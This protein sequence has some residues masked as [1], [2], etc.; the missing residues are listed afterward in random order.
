M[1]V[2]GGCAGGASTGLDAGSPDSGS[3]FDAGLPGEAALRGERI[4][5]RDCASCH[6]LGQPGERRAPDL[7]DVMARRPQR[8]LEHWLDDPAN[9]AANNEYA[10]QL[11]ATWGGVVMPDP[12]LDAA[13]IADVL[14]FLRQQASRGPLQPTPA[15]ALTDADRAAMKQVY[16]DRCAGCHG[17]LRLGGTGPA[18]AAARA[19]ELGTDALVATLRHGRP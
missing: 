16:F 18:L 9:V 13:G 4:F 5:R 11:V 2:L 15:V 12:E 19:T 3:V 1:T 6:G 14:A 10:K 8:W 17:T 7:L